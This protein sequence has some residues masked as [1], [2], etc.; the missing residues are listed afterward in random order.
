MVNSKIIL[1][2]LSYSYFLYRFR[3]RQFKG[4]LSASEFYSNADEDSEP[5]RQITELL[6]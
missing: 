3:Q 5:F 6:A 2:L 1:K 4:R